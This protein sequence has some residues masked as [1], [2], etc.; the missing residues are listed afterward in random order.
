MEA[1]A[2][3]GLERGGP[4]SYYVCMLKLRAHSPSAAPAGRALRF[5]PSPFVIT[6]LLLT[7]CVTAAT[8][9]AQTR[10]LRLPAGSAV[11][12]KGTL[13]PGR[14]NVEYAFRARAGQRISVRLAS[15]RVRYAEGDAAGAV[16][17]V[18]DADDS[19]PPD[20][21]DYPYGGPVSWDGKLPRAGTYRIKVLIEDGPDDPPPAALLRMNQ[22]VNY[23]LVVRF[24][25]R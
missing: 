25:Q 20:F 11:N 22:R 18:L 23:K 1:I 5:K 13:L 16:F 14:G 7:L 21:G 24:P 9:A 19:Q 3:E 10:R 17:F 4:C 8:A 12:V 15:N 2:D 6:S